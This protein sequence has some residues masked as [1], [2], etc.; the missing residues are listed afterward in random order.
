MTV[1]VASEG[2][3]TMTVWPTF[4]GV[5]TSHPGDRLAAASEPLDPAYQR[6]Q[7][8]WEPRQG[9]VVGRARIHAP[10]GE[11]THALYFR[12]PEGAS[13]CGSVKLPHPVRL[14]RPGVIDLNPITN[15]DLQLLAPASE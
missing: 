1:P 13:L 10:A 9:T 11:Y 7:I 8:V 6:G 3:L 12:G 2:L 15:G 5:G 4:A 14:D